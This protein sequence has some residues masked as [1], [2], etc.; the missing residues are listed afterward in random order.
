M[1][2]IIEERK[3]IAFYIKLY[4]LP[5]HKDAREK[6]IAIM[7]GEHPLALL[8]DAFQKKELPKPKLECNQSVIDENI[9]LGQKLG[10][11]GTPGIILPN[12]TLIPGY[13]DAATIL[14]LIDSQ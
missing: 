14:K 2:K 5:M 12:G 8:D 1:K 13:R 9:K 11:S 10:I 6:S 7:C 3:D 4:P